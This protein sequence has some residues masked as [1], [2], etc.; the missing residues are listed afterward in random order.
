MIEEAG[1]LDQN[2]I[3]TITYRDL[4]FEIDLFDDLILLPEEVIEL[5]SNDNI[6]TQPVNL[7]FSRLARNWNLKKSVDVK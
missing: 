1:Y 5:F 2:D 4:T 3:I 7:F 6:E